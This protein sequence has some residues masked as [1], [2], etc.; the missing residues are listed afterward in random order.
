MSSSSGDGKLP[1][2]HVEDSAD[3]RFLVKEAINLTKTP[4]TYH[5]ADGL[6]SAMPFFQSYG[7]HSDLQQRPAL[8]LL[9]YELGGPNG[10]DFLYWL[11]VRKKIT[12]LP[13]VMFSGSPGRDHIAECY[14]SGVD[15]YLTKP[16]DFERLKRIVRTLYVG[17]VS[18]PPGPIPLLNEYRPDPGGNAVKPE[19]V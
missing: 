1:L 14:A 10:V 17:L 9:D 3:D 11:R 18:H 2:L 4:F 6:E 13:V 19:G 15:H 8:V 5:E 16:N 12:S 7:H